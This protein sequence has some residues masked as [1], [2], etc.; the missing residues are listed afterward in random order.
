[1]LTIADDNALAALERVRARI[2]RGRPVFHTFHCQGELLLYDLCSGS[3]VQLDEGSFELLRGLEEGRESREILAAVAAAGGDPAELVRTLG[4]LEALGL[5]RS[6]PP[7]IAEERQATLDALRAHRQRNLMLL[8]HT[9]CNLACGYCYEV[10]SG[11]HGTGGRMRF[12]EAREILE[13]Y[14]ERSGARTAIEITFF[15]GEPL[16]NFSVIERCVAHARTRAA[17]LGK[18][19]GFTITTNGTLLDERITRFLVA[20]R[21]AVML[22]VDGDP[23]L[24]DRWRR[25]RA[26][27]G[28]TELAIRKGLALVA[29]Q[30]TAGL[31]EAL[32]RVTL[33][34]GNDSRH[35]AFRYLWERGFRR[36][37]VGAAGGRAHAKGAWDLDREATERLAGEH[38]ALV[39]SYADAVERGEPVPPEAASLDKSLERIHEGLAQPMRRA[40]VGCGVG[41]NMLAVAADGRIYP[42]HRFAGEDAHQLGNVNERGLDRERLDRFYAGILRAYDETCSR[43][44]ARFVC[45]GRCPWYLARP[46]GTIGNP[47]EEG[48]DQLRASLERNLW[49]YRKVRL[50]REEEQ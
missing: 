15:G 9:A 4:E 1:M 33:A 6:E 13:D 39:R 30:R 44:W 18:Q 47:D 31:R 29:A 37:M 32:V 7:E 10:A 16:L 48:C 17:E 25:D 45:G 28:T 46:D 11:F 41:N 27:N 20:N 38:D 42:C 22:S 23:V 50:E 24:A 43:C 5:F 3:L 40:S 26:G 49:L 19:I 14:F 2:P 21:F 8:V 35:E 36:I 34:T 12:E